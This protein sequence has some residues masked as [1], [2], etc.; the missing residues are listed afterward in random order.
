MGL[1]WVWGDPS[2]GTL[3][4][5][6][7]F[8]YF[9]RIGINNFL[10]LTPDLQLVLDPASNPLHDQVWVLGLRLQAAF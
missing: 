2:D 4:E 10:T 8:E 6:Q 7:I 9:Y 1:G 3:R 5:E